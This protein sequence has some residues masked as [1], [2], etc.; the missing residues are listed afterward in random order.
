[1]DPNQ[2]AL[3]TAAEHLG[4]LL[5]QAANAH[6]LEDAPGR[7]VWRQLA[8]AAVACSIRTTPFTSKL[9]AAISF[10]SSS[11][12]SSEARSPRRWMSKPNPSRTAPSRR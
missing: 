6:E 5:E 2:K 4:E 1:M 10:A 7:D 9:S 3:A 8:E 11:K 12:R